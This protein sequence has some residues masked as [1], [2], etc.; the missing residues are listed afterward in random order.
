MPSAAPA[1]SSS[2]SSCSSSMVSASASRSSQR[3]TFGAGAR[4]SFDEAWDEGRRKA[5]GILIATIGFYF[6]VYVARLYR[7]HVEQP[8]RADRARARRRVLSDLHD[9][10]RSDRRDAGKSC[11]RRVVPSRARKA[12]SARPSSRSSSSSLDMAARFHRR[13]ARRRSRRD[14]CTS[15]CWRRQSDRTRPISP[16]RSRRSTTTSRLEDTGKRHSH[17]LADQWRD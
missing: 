9:T 15:S 4:A 12:C 16:F 1:A 11:N 6:L 14:R 13:P 5:G 3:T 10:G 7:W 2:K 17:E 8:V